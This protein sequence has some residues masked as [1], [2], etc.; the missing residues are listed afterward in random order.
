MIQS[1]IQVN[2]T[3]NDAGPPPDEIRHQLEMAGFEVRREP[4][5]LVVGLPQAILFSPGDDHIGSGAL[6]MLEQVAGILR[7]VPNQVILV[8]HADSVPIRQSGGFKM[9]I[10][11][12]CL[13]GRR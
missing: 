10:R 6:P 2:D 5:G 3:A 8:G 7:S 11:E 9:S 1:T 13:A 4:R 12:L